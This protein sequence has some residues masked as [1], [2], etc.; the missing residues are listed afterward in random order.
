MKLNLQIKKTTGISENGMRNINSTSSSFG[1]LITGGCVYV[2]K[3]EYL[4]ELIT[5]R[6]VY[7]FLSRPRRFGKSLTVSTLQAIFEGR[8]ELF[9]GLYIG[10][11]GYDFKKHPVIRIDFALLELQNADFLRKTLL[12]KLNRIAEENDI[13]LNEKEFVK[14][15]F[16]ELIEKL[17]QKYGKVVV[18]ID[19]YDKPLSDSIDNVTN[20]VEIRDVLRGFYEALKASAEYLRFV[21]ITGVTKYSKMSIFSSM[22]NLNDLSLNPRYATLLGYTQE[23]LEHYFAEGI[24]EGSKAL[25]ISKDEYIKKVKQWYDGYCFAPNARTVYNPVS[26]GLFFFSEGRFFYNYWM[27]TGGRALLVYDI[28]KQVDF[29]ISTDLDTPISVDTLTSYDITELTGKNVNVDSYKSL[30]LQ[31]GY[32]TIK[33]ALGS[34]GQMFILGFPNEEV[35]EGYLKNLVGV[36]LGESAAMGFVPNYL[37]EFF[38]R[39]E[40]QKGIAVIKSIFAKASYN[41]TTKLN[42]AAF[43]MAIY[44]MMKAI[45]ADID[46]EVPTNHGRIDAVLKTPEHIYVIEYKVDCSV[47]KAL[48]QIKD[49]HYADMFESDK[50]NG[51]TVHLVGVN[52]S[53]EG[54]NISEYKELLL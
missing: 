39:G 21:F 7:F 41:V 38:M 29:N 52:F 23:E 36:Y 11:T 40:T 2:D 34:S 18:L 19:E 10:K 17:Y 42:E 35:R 48:Q 49:K 50:Q 4:H 13:V 22:N 33:E 3:T 9:E 53:T 12:W 28:A 14:S 5:S 32:L 1:S 27:N 25:N 15:A 26:I 16:Q 30:L 45:G 51:K 44:T 24:D 46:I 31:T 37:G 43:E 54:F 8:K 6:D 47:D 20:A